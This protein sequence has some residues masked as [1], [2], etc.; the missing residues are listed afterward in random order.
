MLTLNDCNKQDIINYLTNSWE[1]EDLLFKS[2]INSETFYLNPDSL[3]NPLI[4]YLG[5]S[6]VFYI[7]K[8][9]ILGLLKESQRI[10]PD[11]EKL[12]EIGV[13]PETPN[14]LQKA[15]ASIKWAKVEE[16]WQYRHQAYKTVINIIEKTPLTL[17]ITPDSLWWGIIMSIEHQRIHIE[18]SSMLIRQL[19]LELVRK[20]SQ[21]H[22]AKSQGKPPTNEMIK[23]EGGIVTLGKKKDDNL[24]GWDVDFGEKEVIINPFQV[25]KYLITNGEFLEFVNNKGYDNEH[26]W[27]EISWQ[28]KLENKASYPK[29]WR[30]LSQNYSYRLMFD[31]IDL[32]L[33]FPVEVNHHEANA[34]CRYLS[35]KLGDKYQ[36][37]SESQ[38]QFLQ[39]KSVDNINNYNLNFKFISPHC[40][41]SLETSK[42]DQNIYDLRGNVWEWL[43]DIFTPLSSFKPHYLYQDYSA[44]FFDNRHYMLLGGSWATNGYEATP[45]YRNWFRPYF[46]Q[47]AGFR[48]ILGDNSH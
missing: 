1:T 17:P 27:D 11:Y 36:L 16:L 23:I 20:P 25:S 6:A 31:E 2:I 32:P 38:W 10:N 5:H 46:Y 30:K 3:R 40:V 44:P 47:H 39:Q 37:M 18:T 28:W 9:V 41:G 42:N 43:G 22:Y 48:I 45:Y 15:I 12:Y 24:Y 19:P 35:Q 7:N 29:F 14:E 26:Y 34:Y 13:D 8:L 21:W 4:F 33:D